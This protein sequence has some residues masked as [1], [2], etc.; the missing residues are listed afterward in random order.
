MVTFLTALITLDMVT[1]VSATTDYKQ[2][3]EVSME[4]VAVGE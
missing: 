4:E 1:G 3:V 2:E